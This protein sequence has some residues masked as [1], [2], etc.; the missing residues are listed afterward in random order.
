M[1][2][3]KIDLILRDL[4]KISYENK[5]ELKQWKVQEVKKINENTYNSIEPEKSFLTGNSS[6][7]DNTG[8]IF[9]FHYRIKLPQKLEKE[10]LYL[11]LDIDGECTL[12]INND[13]Y[14]GLNEKDI[15]LPKT[16]DNF[17]HFKILATYDIHLYAR[18]QRMFNQP[19]PPH[20]FRKAFLFNKNKSVENLYYDYTAENGLLNPS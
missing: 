20:L 3:D 15:K 19:Y 8:K 5:H 13:V 18:H 16:T 12:F 10:N 1:L 17:Y 9:F 14:R 11:H 7:W 2:P 4:K 6:F